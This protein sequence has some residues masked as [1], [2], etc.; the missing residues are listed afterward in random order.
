MNAIVLDIEA[1]ASPIAD[2][3]RE[4]IEAM[5]AKREQD[6]DTFCAL[7][8]ALAR[9]VAVGLMNVDSGNRR[10][11]FDASLVDAPG[12]L[13]AIDL[14]GRPNEAGVLA[15][16]HELLKARAKTLV[17]FNGRGYDVP[18]LLHRAV[19]HGLTPAPIVSASAWQK[20]WENR[21]H[22]D[23]LAQL[24]FGGATGKFPLAAYAIAHGVGNPKAGGDGSHVAELVRQR[25]G[26]ALCQYVSDDVEATRGLA[27]RWGLIP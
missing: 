9:V 17:T 23:M 27:Q 8:P 7:C 16:V 6:A 24:T 13:D 25:D 21:P 4:T 22:V 12:K 20:P 19:V 26:Q 2:A 11:I 15:A 14:V 5:A 18:L 3:D 1:I 10:V